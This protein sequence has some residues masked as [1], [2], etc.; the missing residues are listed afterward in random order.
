M[1]LVWHVILQ[2]HMMKRSCDF[3][4]RRPLMQVTI[5]QKLVAIT[6]LVVEL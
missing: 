3:M 2:D 1:A 5:L 6:T 4:G